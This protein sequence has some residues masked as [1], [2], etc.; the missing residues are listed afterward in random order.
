MRK[1]M[2]SEV[3]S[4]EIETEVIELLKTVHGEK[5]PFLV[6]LTPKDR[7]RM[8]TPG[9][10]Y[11]D[12]IEKAYRNATSKPE[13]LPGFQR[14]EEFTKD[15]DLRASLHRMREELKILDKKLNDTIVKVEAEAFEAARNYYTLAKT[16]ARSGHGLAELVVDELSPHYKRKSSNGGNADDDTGAAEEPVD[17]AT[18]ED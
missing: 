1:S 5:L 18:H 9:I 6:D 15:M 7:R 17:A 11:A 8:A 13:F 2:L 3:V 14:L 4:P 16:A 12:F 10:R